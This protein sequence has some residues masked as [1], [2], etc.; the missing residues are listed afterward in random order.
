MGAIGS[1]LATNLAAISNPPNIRL[2]LR[3]KDYAKR[4]VDNSPTSATNP[5]SPGAIPPLVSLKVERDGLVRR[6]DGFELETM[7]TPDDMDR[8]NQMGRLGQHGHNTMDPNTYVRND[9]IKTLIVSTKAPATIAG[10]RPL[11]PRLSSQSTIV[12]CHNGMGVLEALLDTYW[13]EDL[14]NDGAGY[15]GVYGASASRPSFICAVTSH[16]MWRKSFNHWVHAGKGDLKFG[17]VPNRAVLA[18]IAATPNPPWGPH[19]SNPL[20]NPRSHTT[21]TLAH[22]PNNPTTQG[23]HQTLSALLAT[24]LEPR[25]LP[26]PTLQIAQLQKLAV[27]TSVNCLTAVLG[28]NNGALVGSKLAKGI[29]VD[30]SRE[31]AHVFGA[32][33]AREQG[34]WQPAATPHYTDP[35]EPPHPPPPALASSHPLS[36]ESLT[37]YTL[38]VIMSTSQNL[39]STLQDVL[40]T[41]SGTHQ[42]HPRSPLLFSTRTEIDFINGYVVALGTRYGV[43]TPVT[44]T[45][46]D[47]VK[48]KEEMLGAGAVDRVL[49]SRTSALAR[50]AS[51]PRPQSSSGGSGGSAWRTPR[52]VRADEQQS[53]RRSWAERDRRKESEDRGG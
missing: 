20:L 12:L 15:K 31:C 36:A 38:S 10:M 4:L 5:I 3:K 17:V 6:V 29:V 48:I 40:N 11:L 18:S 13:P 30:V 19:A 37:D 7:P 21:P 8:L 46:G 23:L 44:K 22:L 34:T 24:E 1:L 51:P 2:I 39:S 52:H 27:N 16:G 25:W 9:A 49:E 41:H 32:H 53:R 14:S 33:L 45:L 35:D 28:V 43:P 47:L 42:L 26:L 50:G